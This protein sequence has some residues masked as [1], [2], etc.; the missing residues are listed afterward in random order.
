MQ[1]FN[2]TPF[3]FFLSTFILGISSTFA[4]DQ[5][6]TRE[7]YISRYKDDAVRDMKKTGVPASIT[8]SQACLES[9][10]G[11]SPLAIEANNHFGIKCA[12][13]TGD[14]YTQDDDQRDEC[15]RKY[16]GALESYDDHS[17]FLR[18]RP[19]YADLFLLDNTDYAAWAKGLKK[20]GYATNPQYAERL[21]KII[22]D[23]KLYELDRGNDIPKEIYES[24]ASSRPEPILKKTTATPSRILVPTSAVINP[25][26]GHQVFFNNETPYVIATSGDSYRSI[27]DEFEMG[28]WQVLKYNETDKSTPIDEGDKIYLKPKRRIG[29]R[30]FYTVK[31]GQSLHDIAQEQG[32]K[33]R[34]LMKWNDLSENAEVKPGQK[35]YLQSKKS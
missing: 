28:E 15:F 19:R 34:L 2:L 7:Q 5:K 9:Q 6:M 11:N 30:S 4:A 21:I 3:L 25:F 33:L 31:P 35:V 12:N 24:V 17:D 8:L 27:A 32:V 18:T 14:T 10:D 22:E 13:W 20:A 26:G 16:K 1:R 23:N 29:D